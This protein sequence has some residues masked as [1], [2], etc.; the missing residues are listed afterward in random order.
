[1]STAT[2]LPA[3]VIPARHCRELEGVAGLLTRR[4][5]GSSD[6]GNGIAS[7]STSA[8]R[9]GRTL[10]SHDGMAQLAGPMRCMMAGIGRLRMTSASTRTAKPSPKPN[11]CRGRSKSRIKEPKATVGG[12][13][14]DG[15]AAGGAGRAGIQ[16]GRSR[17]WA[18][19][20][21]CGSATR[22]RSR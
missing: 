14:N 18:M 3:P 22:G 1:M 15:M 6:G 9:L 2:D 5:T 16:R 20:S 12:G 8:D 17:A 19:V 13:K 7:S 10:P 11:S 21:S 4:A